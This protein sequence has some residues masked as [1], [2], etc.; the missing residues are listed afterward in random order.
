[1]KGSGERV[2]VWVVVPTY[3]EAENIK[4][5]I[6]S[7]LSNLPD[8][9]IVVVDD[10][11]PDGTAEI[12]EKV[13]LVENRVHLIRRPKKMGYA[14]AV[15]FGL[16]YAISMG[17]EFVGHMDADFSHD[18]KILPYLLKELEKGADMVI[19]S[20]YIFGGKFK[21]SIQRKILSLAANFLVR[22]LLSLP[23]RDCTSGFRFYRKDAIKKLPLRELKVKGNSFLSLCAAFAFWNKLKI[24]EVPIFFVERRRGRSK[25]SHRE[26]IEAALCLIKIFIWKKTG[27]WL[28]ASLL[29]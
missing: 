11:S 1:M 22:K 9:F 6:S 20:R 25:L 23:I 2:R 14:S 19:G 5:L 29:S 7:I 13:K 4:E 17:A 18:P 15:I 26:I 10:N 16:I 24:S 27:R 8:S 21:G 12:V 28:G 3:N